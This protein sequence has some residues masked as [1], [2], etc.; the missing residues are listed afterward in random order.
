MEAWHE[1]NGMEWGFFFARQ[2]I[3]CISLCLMASCFYGQVG[4]ERFS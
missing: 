4:H 3:V 2:N 1:W